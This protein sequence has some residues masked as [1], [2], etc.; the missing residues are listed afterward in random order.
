MKDP[1]N[2]RKAKQTNQ[3]R[4]HTHRLVNGALAGRRTLTCAPQEDDE[5]K[6]KERNVAVEKAIEVRPKENVLLF[7]RPTLKLYF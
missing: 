4:T 7:L 1:A 3:D 6:Q 2:D 5:I